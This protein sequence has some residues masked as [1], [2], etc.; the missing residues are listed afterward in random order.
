MYLFRYIKDVNDYV[1]R[2]YHYKNEKGFNKRIY[3][4]NVLYINSQPRY[5]LGRLIDKLIRLYDSIYHSIKE[6]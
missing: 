4:R 5:L 3:W 2:T 6:G 1:K